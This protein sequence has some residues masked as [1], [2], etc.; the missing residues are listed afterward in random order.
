MPSLFSQPVHLKKAEEYLKPAPKGQPYSVPL[1]NSEK[2]GRSK[3][4]R[5]WRF[6]DG[7]LE[8]LDPAVRTVHDMFEST[9]ARSPNAPLFGYRPYDSTK[10]AYGPF[11]WLDVETV[12]QRRAALGAGLAELHAREGITGTQYG[13]G[14]WCQNRPEWQLTDLACMSQSLYSVSLYDT[15]GPEA[16]E[17]II[18]H[19]HQ[20]CPSR[21]FCHHWQQIWM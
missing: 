21:P 11:E 20:V 1:P 13:V 4:Y 8:T 16:S 18:R 7:L 3:V 10:K 15:L 6:R 9:A 12:Q 2:P 17:Y 14:L 5:N 19:A